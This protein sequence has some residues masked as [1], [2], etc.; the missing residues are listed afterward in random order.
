MLK[1][2]GG[3]GGEPNVVVSLLSPILLP[4]VWPLLDQTGK[5]TLPPPHASGGVMPPAGV[6]KK[7]GYS[8]FFLRYA[9]A[10]GATE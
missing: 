6:N 7:P 5:I 8:A 9:G 2:C 1:T 10:Y 4:L 3:H